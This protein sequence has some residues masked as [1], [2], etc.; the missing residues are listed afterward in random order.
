[1]LTSKNEYYDQTFTALNLKKSTLTRK[2][3]EACLFD[4]CDFSEAE[5][6][7]CH[8]IECEFINCNLSLIKPNFSKFNAVKFIDCKAVGV[9]W[10]RAAWASIGI[11][12]PLH[13]ERCLLHDSSFFG[14]ALQ[15]TV[16]IECEIHNADFGETNCESADFSYSDLQDTSFHHAN[17][18]A[19]NFEEAKNYH[20]DILNC[21]VKQARFSL[22]EAVQL[23]SS[24]DIKIL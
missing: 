4:N 6:A 21:N 3:F 19:A 5:L 16:F 2:H 23:L 11:A 7:Y 1:M 12:Y 18:G 9:N 15:N 17:L 8:F 24:L 13:F 14:L 22:P 10:T 20:I